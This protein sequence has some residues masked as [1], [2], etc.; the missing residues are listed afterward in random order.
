MSLESCPRHRTARAY[1]GHCAACLLEHAIVPEVAGDTAPVGQFTIEVPLG[2]STHSSVFLVRGDWPWRRLLRLKQ[3]AQPA[4]GPFLTR[5]TDLRSGLEAFAHPSIVI[6]VAAWL[7]PDGT[8]AALTEFR[9]GIPLLQ[10]VGCGRLGRAA[11]VS[12]VRE[13]R[14]VVVSAH[15]AGLVHG[16]VG[17]GNVF[18]SASGDMAFVLDFGFR[19]ALSTAAADHTWRASDLSGFDSLESRVLA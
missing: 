6:P 11:A 19:T 5:F 15:G 2:R 18:V 13:L 17:P 3:W 4:P 1:R 10:A 7:E 16:S 12:L 8:P 9:Q 14:Q